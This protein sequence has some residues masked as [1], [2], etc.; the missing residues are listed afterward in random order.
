MNF[1]KAIENLLAGKAITH[2]RGDWKFFGEEIASAPDPRFFL[3]NGEVCFCSCKHPSVCVNPNNS[4]LT[5]LPQEL[6]N[7][8]EWQIWEPTPKVNPELEQLKKQSAELVKQQNEL[9]DR[10]KQLEIK[11]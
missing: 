10:I 7:S 6:I 1:A 4:G 11:Q 2:P 8:T 3:K 5:Y 9:N